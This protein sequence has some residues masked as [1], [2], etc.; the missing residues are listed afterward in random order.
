MRHKL[1]KL[2]TE[3]DPKFANLGTFCAQQERQA[4]V[5]LFKQYRDVFTWTYDY[6]KTYDKR[7]AQHI[8]KIKE[9]AKPYQQKLRK[10][11][12]SLEPL[13]QKELTKLL[14]AR[15]IY[16]VH[17]STWVSNLVHVRYNHVLVAEPD[18]LKTTFRTKWGT[19]AYRR[20]SFGLVNTGATF[21]HA[22]DVA[23]HGLIRER[24]VVYL[25]DVTVFSRRQE[26]HT[27]HLKKTFERC[28]RY[29]ISL[30]PKSSVFAVSEGNLLGHIVAKIRIKVDPDRV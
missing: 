10:V 3:K 9:G 21:Q 13:I 18:R 15:N 12:P 1:I 8:I 26:D 16:K 29:E 23:F 4:F 27:C 14:D 2:G 11:H 19:F 6:L 25:N 28:R 17:H 5:C 30:N 22:M 7:I 20:M 24:V